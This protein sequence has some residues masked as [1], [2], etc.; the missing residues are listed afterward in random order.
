MSHV[1]AF[2]CLVTNIVVT[3]KT[4]Q[5]RVII[6]I[7]LVNVLCSWALLWIS[8]ANL[9]RVELFRASVSPRV[10]ASQ[11]AHHSLCCKD[12]S[13]PQGKSHLRPLLSPHALFHDQKLAAIDVAKRTSTLYVRRNHF[14]S[15]S[16]I[17][18]DYILETRDIR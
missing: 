8:I 4:E 13:H 11:S 3:T 9:Q 16:Q 18:A 7:S 6:N 2:Q 17:E 5:P 10:H 14:A 15:G 12:T 1:E